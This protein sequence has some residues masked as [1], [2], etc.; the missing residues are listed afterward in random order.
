MLPHL[1]K[2]PNTIPDD[3]FHCAVVKNL[4]LQMILRILQLITY[5]ASPKQWSSQKKAA[6]LVASKIRYPLNRMLF[7]P[8]FWRLQRLTS[9]FVFIRFDVD[10][11][12]EIKALTDINR[13]TGPRI[14]FL[15]GNLTDLFVNCTDYPGMLHSRLNE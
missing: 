4:T 15:D 5:L 9:E 6:W 10:C 13:S 7:K 12:L 8:M 14:V 11:N 2:N 1:V 3:I